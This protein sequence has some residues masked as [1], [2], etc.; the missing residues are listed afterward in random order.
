MQVRYY[1]VEFTIQGKHFPCLVKFREG[2]RHWVC[3]YLNKDNGNDWFIRKEVA[4]QDLLKHGKEVDES[5][6]DFYSEKLLK[7][8]TH[9]QFVSSY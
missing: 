5:L 3:L 6:F 4:S 9:E 8:F 2:D 7:Q 1:K